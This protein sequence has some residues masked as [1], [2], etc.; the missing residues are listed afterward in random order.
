MLFKKEL[1]IF[2][3]SISTISSQTLNIKNIKVENKYPVKVIGS[4]SDSLILADPMDF[5]YKGG[6]ILFCFR[7]NWN[8]PPDLLV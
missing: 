8:F 6:K 4:E 2:L 5:C 7:W 1:M 3:V